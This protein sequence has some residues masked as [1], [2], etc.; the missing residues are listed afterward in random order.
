MGVYITTSKSPTL[1]SLGLCKTL[2]KALPGSCFEPR[3]GK[4]V[5]QVVERARSKGLSRALITAGKEE[6]ALIR[7]IH[8]KASSWEWLPEELTVSNLTKSEAVHELG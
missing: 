6:G 8:V 7:F 4:T 5:E 3:G 1:F 2:A